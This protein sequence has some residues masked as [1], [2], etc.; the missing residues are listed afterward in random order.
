MAR[1]TL[2]WI[3]SLT[4]GL[5]ARRCETRQRKAARTILSYNDKLA[6]F[7][8]DKLE[9]YVTSFEILTMIRHCFFVF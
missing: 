2:T 4:L 3:L 7:N 1:N 9:I 8:E 6:I 5:D